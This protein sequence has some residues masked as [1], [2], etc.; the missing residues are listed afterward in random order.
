MA[1]K[2]AVAILLLPPEMMAVL[3]GNVRSEAVL[4]WQCVCLCEAV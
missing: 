3:C 4:L 2:A 1:G